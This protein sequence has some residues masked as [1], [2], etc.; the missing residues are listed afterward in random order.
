MWPLLCSI[1][2]ILIPEVGT[3]VLQRPPKCL[4]SKI[5]DGGRLTWIAAQGL[6]KLWAEIRSKLAC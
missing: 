1:L 5:A 2:D 6:D 4:N 3:A